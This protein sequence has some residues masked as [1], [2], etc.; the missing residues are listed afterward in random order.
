MS[1][2]EKWQCTEGG[3]LKDSKSYLTFWSNF[4]TKSES[5][6]QLYSEEAVVEAAGGNLV[7][8]SYLKKPSNFAIALWKRMKKNSKNAIFLWTLLMRC[9][10]LATF[11]WVLHREQV[12]IS[13]LTKPTWP[14]GL[15]IRYK[16]V[17]AHYASTFFATVHWC[18]WRHQFLNQ[19][20]S[21]EFS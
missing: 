17:M 10:F 6:K 13:I 3:P 15:D 20:F 8:N 16:M 18:K 11:V 7:I 14:I 9:P 21:L 4:A 5:A 12:W 19:L 1:A 2:L